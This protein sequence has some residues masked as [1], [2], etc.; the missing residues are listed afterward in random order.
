ML[1]PNR[2]SVN[3]DVWA[4]LRD[5]F[6][7]S[8]EDAIFGSAS[9]N[10]F[11]TTREMRLHDANGRLAATARTSP[12]TDAIEFLDCRGKLVSKVV[13]LGWPWFGAPAACEFYSAGGKLIGW[14]KHIYMSWAQVAV[15]QVQDLDGNEIARMMQ[16]SVGTSVT[17]D[18]KVTL[19]ENLIAQGTDTGWDVLADPRFL[20]LFSSL[21]F[22][23]SAGLAVPLPFALLVTSMA[24]LLCC[25]LPAYYS[26]AAAE[27]GSQNATPFQA[28][29]IAKGTKA[30]HAPGLDRNRDNS[31]SPRDDVNMQRTMMAFKRN[32][33]RARSDSGRT[34][35]NPSWMWSP[36]MSF[37]VGPSVHGEGE[38]KELQPM[39]SMKSPRSMQL[40]KALEEL[41]EDPPA[42]TG[43]FSTLFACTCAANNSAWRRTA[44]ADRLPEMPGRFLDFTSA[45]M[46]AGLLTSGRPLPWQRGRPEHQVPE[47]TKV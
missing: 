20:A 17:T 40:Q 28:L 31:P 16:S 1:L 22:G 37:K 26:H 6:N 4:S 11:S 41:E 27:L 30:P 14:T 44:S 34:V 33:S 3:R 15:V 29:E 13:G 19:P 23:G 2:Y 35:A 42:N 38:P 10:L 24:C 32:S 9:W 5:T 46:A 21:R 25:I 36:L 39:E 18:V 43:L 47:L 45:P 8:S 12:W 7:V